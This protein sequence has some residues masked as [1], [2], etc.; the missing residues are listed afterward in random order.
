[1]SENYFRW[2]FLS[3][4][5]N[6]TGDFLVRDA[7]RINRLYF[8]LFNLQGFMSAITPEA[9]G[10]LKTGQNTFLTE[11]QVTESILQTKNSRNFWIKTDQ[12][13]VASVPGVSA[14]E[15]AAKAKDPKLGNTDVKAGPGF[16]SLLRKVHG[17]DLDAEITYFVPPHAPLEI[18]LVTL[19]N[20]GKKPLSFSAIAAIPLYGRS[21]DN[22]RDHRQVTTLL[23]RVFKNEHGVFLTP[24]M[25]FDE[26]GHKP[27]EM[28]Y[29]ACA[30]KDEGERLDGIIA[31]LETFIGEGGCLEAPEKV[32]SDKPFKDLSD[33]EGRQAI[34]A[35]KFKN[36]TLSSQAL[37][38]FVVT[39]GV[40]KKTDNLNTLFQQFNSTEKAKVAL[41]ATKD[42]WK[43]QV[44]KFKIITE[45]SVFNNWMLWVS[46]QPLMRRVYGCSFLPDFGYGR[47]GRGWRDLWQ[48]CLGL[49]LTCPSDAR[50]LLLN[51]IQG[52]RIDGSNA[53]IIGMNPGEFIADRNNIPRTWMDHGVWPLITIA[54]YIE[55]TGD[56]DIL[57]EKTSFFQDALIF[58]CKKMNPNWSEKKPTRLTIQNGQIF[59]G[60][61]FLHLLIQN[62]T[63]FYNRGEHGNIRLEDAD[64][65]DGLDM[66]HKGGES[67][68]F[69]AL[70]AGNLETLAYYSS[71][72][73]QK[74]IHT[75]EI[76][77]EL[78]P[79]INKA[80]ENDFQKSQIILQEYLEK[81]KDGIRG[82]FTALPLELLEQS[83]KEKAFALK[84]H[85][86][87]Q[88]FLDTGKHRY[89]N[90]YYN[91]DGAR[92][93]GLVDG[94]EQMS[95]TAQVFPILSETATLPQ[96]KDAF[97][98][99]KDLLQDK[100]HGGFHLNTN[101][102]KCM[103]NLG[104]AFS[105]AYGDKENGAFFSHMIVMF[106]NAL[107]RR[108]LVE[109]GFEVISS[110]YT[111]AKNTEKSLIFPCMPEYFDRFGR[112]K[113]CYITGSGA[114]MVMTTLIEMFGIRGAM[115]KLTFAPKLV[116]RQFGSQGTLTV[117]TLF[118]G[119][120]I[121]VTYKNPKNL[122]FG[123]YRVD[124]ISCE[125]KTLSFEWKE[126]AAI[127]NP[128]ELKKLFKKNRTV[129]FE[130]VLTGE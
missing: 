50:E 111:M 42:F 14:E 104:R 108:N 17:L 64:W 55:Q 124:S 12:G 26:R 4:V 113:Y 75:L 5:N 37:V 52:V 59:M 44:E 110:I 92:V 68:P 19:K 80:A 129:E 116:S 103:L 22:L 91:N 31:D 49:L 76:P 11:P 77:E 70:Y 121:R 89:F 6:P 126:N 43:S 84:E 56:W 122:S 71:L 97:R 48:D 13:I 83:L 106:A 69:S 88:E 32:Y 87:K 3:D 95:L 20:T 96:A 57:M 99:A 61:V 94:V 67:V 60:T 53:T 82:I 58:R 23:N 62:L 65:N 21:A 86:R 15:I 9:K 36:V 93:E 73:R 130:I 40:H 63:Q 51:N 33:L 27:G 24:T 35:L 100:D 107:Y 128:V 79:L 120:A 123:Q 29:S 115:G 78:L 34:G 18:T 85:I 45:D 10:D 7:S 54:L 2:E 66:A 41:E 118:Q 39:L 109:E 1:M 25:S 101:F 81:I 125:G 74:G 117:Q 16:F 30:F 127:P 114:W 47:G 38:S 102:G 90:G 112:G 28:V 72:L 8:P 98:A 105:F 119:K 46:L